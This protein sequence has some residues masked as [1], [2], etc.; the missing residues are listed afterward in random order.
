[1]SVADETTSLD[2]TVSEDPKNKQ[3]TR[4]WERYLEAELGFRNHWYPAFFAAELPEA[5]VSDLQGS[6]VK[7]VRTE[8][9]LGERI[10]FRRV[11]GR[12][13]A[14]TDRC[15]HRGVSLAARPECYTKDTITCWY[16]GFT[17][18]MDTG[19]LTAVLTEPRSSLIGQVGLHS[20]PVEERAGLVWVF[21]GD[22]EAP[23]L[24]LDVQPG[25]L[26]ANLA[27]YPQGWSK[28]VECNW[29]TAAE[30]GFD[31]AHA[32]IHRNSAFVTDYKIPMVLGDAGLTRGHGMEVV[33]APDAPKG[34]VLKRG[35]GGGVWEAEVGPGV[36]VTS[37]FRPGEPDVI[38][39]MNPEVS[40]WMPCGLWVEP[41]PAPGIVH[42]EWYVPIDKYHHRYIITWA[43]R[44]NSDEERDAFFKE[45][46][47]NWA[48]Y[49]P[50]VFNQDDVFARNAMREFYDEGNGWREEKLFGPDIV[51]ANW[52]RLIS[53]QARGVQT[54]DKAWARYRPE[55]K[56]V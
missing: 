27:V 48:T 6:P 34:V 3:R 18:A 4:P 36:N 17:Y 2:T 50:A 8:I 29:R 20:Y 24:E 41:M 15:R 47:Q 38:E 39:G 9:L 1:M 19:K 26:D 56:P 37:R 46:A 25:L 42:L 53:R 5:D 54:A 30:N 22:I 11:G 44:V 52:R 33:D 12:I 28:V 51:I 14:I 43:K 10:L 21:I 40:V 49:I 23:P 13:F 7:N 55:P 16:H 31:P 35:G 32:Y 45:T